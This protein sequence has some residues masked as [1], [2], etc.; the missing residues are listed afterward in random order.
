MD[1]KDM[2][3]FKDLTL[4]ERREV[5]PLLA[6]WLNPYTHK[7]IIEKVAPRI[8]EILSTP[9]TMA[10]LSELMEREQEAREDFG[11]GLAHLFDDFETFKDYDLH[12]NALSHPEAYRAVLY[13]L[14]LN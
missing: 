3:I 9:S 5:M 10:L 8:D 11:Q 7:V 12:N 6:N 1:N 2:V 13:D 4:A 14:Y